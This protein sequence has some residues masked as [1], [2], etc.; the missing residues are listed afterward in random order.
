MN[1]QQSKAQQGI[2]SRI[3]DFLT[4]T[5]TYTKQTPPAPPAPLPGTPTFAKTVAPNQP[6]T[7]RPV[8]AEWQPTIQAMYKQ[9]P[10]LPKGILE[11]TLMQE[12]GMGT[13]PSQYHAPN[14]ESAWITGMTPV[15][16]SHLAQRGLKPDLNTQAGAIQGMAHYFGTRQSGVDDKGKSFTYKDPTKLYFERYKTNSS[17]TIATTSEAKKNFKSYVDYYSNSTRDLNSLNK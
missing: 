9:Y 1:P 8:P 11:A 15:A 14:G 2:A 17:N 3:G 6:N 7:P 5:V 10:T 13:N 16:S 12:S 4:N